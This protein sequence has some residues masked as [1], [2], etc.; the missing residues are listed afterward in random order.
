MQNDPESMFIPV[1]I[2]IMLF[3]TDTQREVAFKA[4]H[5]KDERLWVN[6]TV[7]IDQEIK[8]NRRDGANMLKRS[9][10]VYRS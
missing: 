3:L 1:H 9:T 10:R 6:Y 5:T 2:T 7:L 8:N 4:L